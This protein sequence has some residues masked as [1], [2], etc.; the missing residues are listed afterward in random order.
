MVQHHVHSTLGSLPTSAATR[1]T[2][3]TDMSSSDNEKKCG[4]RVS[5]HAFK[6]AFV[7]DELLAVFQMRERVRRYGVASL[8][9]DAFRKRAPL[10][11]EDALVNHLSTMNQRTAMITL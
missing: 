10:L 4:N 3:L 6:L 8:H 11:S 9:Q 2:N 1:S 7:H 5:M